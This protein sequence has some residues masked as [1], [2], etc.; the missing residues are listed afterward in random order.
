M[1]E[2]RDLVVFEDD[3]GNEFTMEVLDYLSYEGRD[4]AMLSELNENCDSCESDT[5][6]GCQTPRDVYI[7][8]VV[9]VDDLQEFLPVEDGDLAETLLDIFQNSDFDEEDLDGDPFDD[10]DD[11]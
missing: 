3:A 10:E 6:E 7:M 8:E 1:E 11:E 4:Y 9:D 5:C 2:E